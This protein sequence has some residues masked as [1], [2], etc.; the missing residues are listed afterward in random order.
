MKVEITVEDAQ[1]KAMLQKLAQ[2]VGNLTPVMREAGRTLKNDAINNFKGQHAPD[3]TPWKRL[4]A[5]TLINRGRRAVGGGSILTKN[6]SRTKVKAYLAM[7]SAQTLLDTGVLRNS[8]QALETTPNSVTVGSRIKYAAIHQFGGMAGK[9]RKVRIPARPF[10][11]MSPQAR[12][13]I[14]N[15]INRHMGTNQ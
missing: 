15:A 5:A 9:G 1:I 2:R 13:D 11:G 4:S 6:R 3:G 12:T 8:V 14:I 10:I 7:T